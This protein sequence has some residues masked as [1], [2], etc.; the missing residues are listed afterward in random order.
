MAGELIRTGPTRCRVDVVAA[1]APIGH[2]RCVDQALLNQ[3]RRWFCVIETDDKGL[4]P[5]VVA[6]LTQLAEMLDTV[7]PSRVDRLRSS[8]RQ[9]GHG[10]TVSRGVEVHLAHD[11]D[12]VADLDIAVGDHEAIVS[13]LST[14]EHTFPEDGD[15]D[16]PWTSVVVDVVA[17]AIRG[18]YEVQNHYRGTR[19]TKSRI[20][21]VADPERPRVLGTTGSL[22]GW[23]PWLGKKRV[24]VQRLDYDP[25]ERSSPPRNR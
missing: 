19:L 8:I 5:N 24:E 21:D 6:C 2:S 13:W 18:E 14:H 16:Q 20:V 7:D 23:L 17:A 10:W 22:F 12:Q 1:G 3:L 11:T 15:A 9:H 4:S 25:R